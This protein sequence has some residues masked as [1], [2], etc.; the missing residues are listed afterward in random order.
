MRSVPITTAVLFL[1][2]AVPAAAQTDGACASDAVE[3]AIDAVSRAASAA[4][5]AID[6]APS[7]TV[8]ASAWTSAF[9][10]AVKSAAGSDGRLSR[11]EAKALGQRSDSSGLFGDN[12]VDWLDAKNQKSVDVEKLIREANRIAFTTGT[13]AAGPDGRL[14]L[15]DADAKLPADLKKDYLFLRG[16][17]GGAPVPVTIASTTDGLDFTSESD[18]RVVYLE[19]AAPVAGPI[20]AD[21]VRAALGAAH[22]RLTTDGT[23]WF[24]PN[25]GYMKIAERS[26][27]TRDFDGF[28]QHLISGADPND[29]AS[30]A[31]AAKFATLRDAMK[32]NLTELTVIR[33]NERPG[34]TAITTSIF[35]VGKTPDG[36]LAGVL[37]AGVET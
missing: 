5:A 8:F 18:A 15:A 25:P 22:D 19:S 35:I 2:F 34:D 10:S 24:S 6:G 28:F 37:T 14:S 30:L 7:A 33:F 9:S 3:P 12:A 4:S 1:A 20:T 21:S 26:P 17:L 36:K 11:S 13:I 29:P 31:M 23:V 32:A 16:R 27:E